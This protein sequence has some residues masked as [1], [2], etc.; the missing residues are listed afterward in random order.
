MIITAYDCTGAN[1]GAAPK[2]QLLGYDTGS[3]GVP[4]TTAD[5]AAHPG[6]VHIDQDVLASDFTADLLDVERGAATIAEAA[7]WFEQA[8]ANFHAAKRPGQRYPGI[9]ISAAYITDLANALKAAGP[10][11]TPRLFIAEWGVAPATADTQITDAA[12]PWP[13]VGCQIAN[14]GAYDVDLV[15]SAWLT[16][17]SKLTEPSPPAWSITVT[18]DLDAAAKLVSS[19]HDAL[20]Q[21]VT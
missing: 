21:N 10:Q 18:H 6:A 9:Y 14:R 16:T 3:A 7:H 1:I 11:V 15:S 12:G 17:V 8:L 20:V 2:G 5:W 13:V 19:A 4:W